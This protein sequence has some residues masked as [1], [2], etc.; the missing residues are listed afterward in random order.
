MLGANAHASHDWVCKADSAGYTGTIFTFRSMLDTEVPLPERYV[1]PRGRIHRY[2][3]DNAVGAA[4]STGMSVLDVGSGRAPIVAA[5]SRPAGVHYAGLDISPDELSVAGTGAYDEALVSDITRF[6]PEYAD[7]FDLVISLYMLEHV[8]PIDAALENMRRYLKPG[9]QMFAQFAG[10]QSVA[11]RLNRVVPDKFVRTVV[12]QVVPGR[13]PDNVF[14]AEYDRCTAS[15]I[16]ALMGDWSVASVT[17]QH[18]GAIN[19]AFSNVILR[20]YL[21]AEDALINRPD[22]AT[23]YLITAIR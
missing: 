18:T 19:F 14:P 15:A 10:G 6:E 2:P 11:A 22:A 8:R 7:R 21:S 4:L 3:L 13:V 16:Q 1:G 23:R 5:G 17:P 20:A 9:G 12:S